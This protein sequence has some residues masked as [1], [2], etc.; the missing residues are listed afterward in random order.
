MVFS[1]GVLNIFPNKVLAASVPEITYVKT[2]GVDNRKLVFV[3]NPEEIHAEAGACDLADNLAVG[4]TYCGRS[5][6]R[7][8]GAIGNYRNWWEHINKTNRSIGYGVKLYNPGPNSATVTVKG[9]GFTL[10]AG[11]LG[12]KEFVD[13]FNSYGSTVYTVNPTNT[14]WVYQT[15]TNNH[16]VQGQFFAGVVDFNI[17]GQGLIM[18]NVAY[19]SNLNPSLVY[20]G[21][22][23]RVM[24]A[25]HESLV[26]KGLSSTTEVLASNVNFTVS[27]LDQS[28]RL[29]VR[30]PLYNMPQQN[31]IP[32]TEG[33]CS[34]SL[35]PYCQGDIGGYSESS[36]TRDSWITH[37][38][39]DPNDPNPKRQN[40]VTTDIATLYMPGLPS[41][42]TLE[43]ANPSTTCFEISPFYK[44]YYNDFAAWKYPNWGNWAIHYKLSGSITNTGTR[45]RT[46]HIG[47]RAD[48]NA[49]IAYKG[50]DGVWR[51]F[52]MTK[53]DPANPN[54]YFPYSY[55]SVNS[56]QTLNY[57][58]DVILSGPGSGT[59]ENL[60]KLTN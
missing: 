52:L 29:N 25:V 9:K 49:P 43:T 39:P 41:S 33:Y 20:I 7:I 31:V 51:Q 58:A 12:G 21:Y 27:D 10:N 55:L 35:S 17:S 47:I 8:T 3:N 53:A 34:T 36:T 30:Y 14:L 60:F 5:I 19:D 32:S 26:Y 1:G 48:G 56:G 13:M 59:F 11:S 40:A 2:G 57:N 37:I 22:I 54:D 38:S 44:W 24:G 23:T 18:D 6:H 15:P 46:F 45:T 4:G 50:Q 28:G 16:I 42:C